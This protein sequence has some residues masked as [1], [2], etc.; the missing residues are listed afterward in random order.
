MHD[1]A[2][3]RVAARVISDS[4][5][6]ILVDVLQDI[7]RSYDVELSLEGKSGARRTDTGRRGATRSRAKRQAGN[8]LKTSPPA[9]RQHRAS[10][11]CDAGEHESSSTSDHRESSEPTG[12]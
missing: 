9:T 7:E 4:A 8:Q 5:T 12:K 10:A 6:S 3:P 11:R 2:A 1:P